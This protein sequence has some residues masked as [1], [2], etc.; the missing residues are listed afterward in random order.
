MFYH[1]QS[2]AGSA[3]CSH[4]CYLQ[5]LCSLLTSLYF[6]LLTL[7]HLPLRTVQLYPSLLSAKALHSCVSPIWIFPGLSLKPFLQT[8]NWS[9]ACCEPCGPTSFGASC[10]N[11]FEVNPYVL[12]DYPYCPCPV[13]A[14]SQQLQQVQARKACRW[15]LLTFKTTRNGQHSRPV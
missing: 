13:Q 15:T 1:A 6:S 4:V 12:L 14:L 7:W 8:T 5:K 3:D 11:C 2:Q 10:V 9:H